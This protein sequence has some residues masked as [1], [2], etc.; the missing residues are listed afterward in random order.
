MTPIGPGNIAQA[1]G[2]DEFVEIV[3]LKKAAFVFGR[4]A[5]RFALDT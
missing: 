3:E 4:L 1:Q 2:P 5:E